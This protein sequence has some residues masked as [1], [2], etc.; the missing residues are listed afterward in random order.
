VLLSLD[1]RQKQRH[2][3][4]DIA[5]D[6]AVRA[7]VGGGQVEVAVVVEVS[8]RLSPRPSTLDQRFVQYIL[9]CT[10][11]RAARAHLAIIRTLHCVS[12]CTASM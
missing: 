2:L 9:L 12:R 5:E 10:R 8:P 11:K 6:D 7:E 3:P 1:Q 4:G